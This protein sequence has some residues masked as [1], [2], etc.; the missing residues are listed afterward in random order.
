M[1]LA[2]TRTVRLL[3]LRFVRPRIQRPITR[4]RLKMACVMWSYWRVMT[5][6]VIRPLDRARAVVRF[7]RVDWH[8]QHAHWPAEIGHIAQ[9]LGDRRAWAG[10]VMV[11]AGC[12]NG[13]STAKFSILCALLGYD[14]RVYDSFEG[15]GMTEEE[16][17]ISYDFTGEYAAAE[18]DVRAV[19]ARYGEP[20][21]CSYHAGWYSETLAE[22]VPAPVRVAYIDCDTASGTEEALVGILPSLVDDGV[23]FSQDFHIKTVRDLLQS[24]DVW[25]VLGVARP[26]QRQLGTKLA[27]LRWEAGVGRHSVSGWRRH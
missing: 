4:Q 17:A 8:V 26:T 10:E 18:D 7:L 23:V 24:R 14:L 20:Y 15:V 2:R 11:E 5:V 1:K 25:D 27:R 3:Y 19:V 21:V 9:A 6:P 16:R 22:P 13:G 12:W